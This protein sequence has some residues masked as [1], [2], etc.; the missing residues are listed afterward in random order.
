MYLVGSPEVRLVGVCHLGGVILRRDDA[1]LC[2]KLDK[3]TIRT[4]ARPRGGVHNVRARIKL[5]TTIGTHLTAGSAWA[6][7]PRCRSFEHSG[8]FRARSL[9]IS[10]VPAPGVLAL[11]PGNDGFWSKVERVLPSH[12]RIPKNE[13]DGDFAET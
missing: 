9:L 13:L 5:S 10:V 4:Q 8:I 3:R 2:L 7:A 1:T 6:V 12:R 11:C